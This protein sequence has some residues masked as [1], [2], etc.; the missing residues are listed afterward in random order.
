MGKSTLIVLI[1]H[2]D[3]S[4]ELMARLKKQARRLAQASKAGASPENQRCA[5]KKP[6]DYFP[7][8]K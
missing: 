8:H 1:N 5:C 2:H 6:L 7:H 3:Q 4:W